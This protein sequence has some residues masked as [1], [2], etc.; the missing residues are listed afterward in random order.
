MVGSLIGDALLPLN[1]DD[2]V[3]LKE[4]WILLC[5]RK[6]YKRISDHLFANL[7]WSTNGSC[8][9]RSWFQIHKQASKRTDEEQIQWNGHGKVHNLR[10]DVAVVLKWAIHGRKLS[11]VTELKHLPRRNR[12]TFLRRVWET[13]Y[14][15]HKVSAC[16]YY[17]YRWCS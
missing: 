12:P 5:I 17:T 13:D 1:M 6:F 7:G 2:L 9:N 14:Q 16:S 15:L 11:N 4:A 8:S 10:R 3:S